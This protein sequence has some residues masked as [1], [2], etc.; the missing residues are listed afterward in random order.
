MSNDNCPRCQSEHVSIA[1]FRLVGYPSRTV[2]CR[3]CKRSTD[4]WPGDRRAAA[5]IGL[6]DKT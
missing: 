2:Y 6:E 3:E 4:E 1:H 5:G